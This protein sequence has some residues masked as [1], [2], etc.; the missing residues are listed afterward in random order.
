MQIYILIFSNG[1]QMLN[2]K[3][4]NYIGSSTNIFN[5][6]VTADTN[7]RFSLNNSGNAAQDTF[8]TRTGN[9]TLSLSGSTDSNLIVTSNTAGL[10]V[11]GR[12]Y[13]N[14]QFLLGLSFNYGSIQAI[15]QRT[16]YYPL[17]LNP[18]GG[19]VSINTLV[20]PFF[21]LMFQEK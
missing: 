16:G 20:V 9:S 13:P 1:A 18:F 17:L 5:V 10:V 19:Y 3:M 8:L 4:L 2:N 14:F 11:A 21:H 6:Q 7:Y 15:N 12:T